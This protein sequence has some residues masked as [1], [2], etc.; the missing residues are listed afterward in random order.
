L[1]AVRKS[2]G[3]EAEDWSEDL[4][5]SWVDEETRSAIRSS[6]NRSD[7]NGIDAKEDGEE[8]GEEVEGEEEEERAYVDELDSML[9]EMW[10]TYR[11]RKATLSGGSQSALKS[12]KS[13]RV[14][15][16]LNAELPSGDAAAAAAE[17]GE[18][19]DDELA[20]ERNYE[21]A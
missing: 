5:E 13:R 4:D 14:D 10:R 12:K 15:D 11:E 7:S 21:A 3:L 6:K 9:E 20:R 8:E 2:S 16:D 18:E 19:E 1:A 17:N